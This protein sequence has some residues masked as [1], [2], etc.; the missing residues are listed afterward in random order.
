MKKKT[1]LKLFVV[2][3]FLSYIDEDSIYKKWITSSAQDEFGYIVFIFFSNKRTMK[4]KNDTTFRIRFAFKACSLLDFFFFIFYVKY[5]LMCLQ[6]ISNNRCRGDKDIEII[7]NNI[8]TNNSL[9]R[10]T[11]FQYIATHETEISSNQ[12]TRK[13]TLTCIH[14]RRIFVYAYDDISV[15]TIHDK[16]EREKKKKKQGTFFR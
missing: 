9:D 16:S 2:T 12:Y 3:F 6:M 15:T 7:Q 13:F 5:V 11:N 10:P 8:N 1:Q 4:T 14:W